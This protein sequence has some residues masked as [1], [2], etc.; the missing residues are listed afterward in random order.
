MNRRFFVLVFLFTFPLYAQKATTAII[1]GTLVNT[2]GSPPIENAT[3]LLA[4]EEI[5]QAGPAET[6]EVPPGVEIISAKGKWIIPGLIDAHIHFF[7]SGGL[8]TRPDII[9]LRKHVPYVD[10]EIRQI[11]DEI[12]AKYAYES[13]AWYSTSRLWDDG[14]IDPVDTRKV[15]AMGIAMSLNKPYPDPKTGVYRM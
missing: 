10:E 8:Y 9:D 11:K 6:I 1:G 5:L 3:I 15:V 2:D 7:Q 12:L 4:G 14:I 13:S